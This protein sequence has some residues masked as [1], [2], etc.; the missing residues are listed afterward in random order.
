[1]TLKH[2]VRLNHSSKSQSWV[3]NQAPSGYPFCLFRNELE[4]GNAESSNQNAMMVLVGRVGAVAR[5]T[6]QKLGDRF[7]LRDSWHLCFISKVSQLSRANG[8][9]AHS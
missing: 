9:R 8:P 6:D 5:G 3:A 1:M 4:E 2:L 7:D